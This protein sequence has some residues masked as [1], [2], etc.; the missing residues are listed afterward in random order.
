VADY[1]SQ[2]DLQSHWK[3]SKL[4]IHLFKWSYVLYTPYKKVLIVAPCSALCMLYGF[5]CL[6][7][8]STLKLIHINHVSTIWLLPLYFTAQNWKENSHEI[9]AFRFFHFSIS[10]LRI[11]FL[12]S[13]Y[14]ICRRQPHYKWRY[15][16]R[17]LN[18]FV[19]VCAVLRSINHGCK[20]V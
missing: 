3:V 15:I 2:A 1:L 12:W 20:L 9:S 16:Y 6:Q 11:S 17:V 7:K 19:T 13:V 5:R 8:P 4:K 14:C 18:I 10:H